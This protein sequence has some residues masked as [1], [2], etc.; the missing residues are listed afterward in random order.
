MR[1]KSRVRCFNYSAYGHFAFECKKPRR[2]R[3]QQ[4]QESNLTR[5]EDD[6]PALLLAKLEPA[7]S[8]V[9]LL[10]DSAVKPQL[11]EKGE[12]KMYES[13]LWYID[14]GSSNHMTGQKSKFKELDERITGRVK[15]GDGSTVDIQGR[16]SIALKC[17]D[18]QE[19]TLNE[20]YF[21]PNLRSNII[22]VGQLTEDG[23]KVVIKGDFMWVYDKEEKLLMKIKKSQNRL[24]RIIIK[25]ENHNCMLSKLEDASKLWH[26]RLGHVNYQ[27]LG[28]MCRDEMV[29]GM[30]RI[31]Q[32]KEL[33][34]G[35]LMLK[36]ARNNIPKKSKFTAQ[37]VLELVHADLYGPITPE[38]AAGNKYFFLLVDDYS[39]LMWVYLLKTKNE[40]FGAFK[41][42]KAMVEDGKERR[43][44][45]LRTDR[46]GEFVSNEFS[47]YCEEA[48]IIRHYTNLYTPQQN[49]VVERRNRTVM[50]MARSLLKGKEMPSYFWGEA[51][52]HAV[53][54]L[55][56]L[57]TRA[58]M[59]TT[60]YETWTSYKPDVGHLPVFG[61][62]GHMK[63]PAQNTQ[64]LDNR[65]MDIV[66]LGRESG[67]KIYRLY[68]PDEN[69]IYVS[70]DVVF[71]ESKSWAWEE[72]KNE[73]AVELTFPVDE[74][75]QEQATETGEQTLVNH[76]SEPEA[77]TSS[78]QSTLP[79]LDPENYD[80]SIEPRRTRLL[81]DVYNDF[82]E[83][84]MDEELYL[85]ETEERAN[86]EEASK[87]KSWKRA[88]EAEI[89]SIEKNNTWRL[90]ELP[91][92][93]KV[94]GLKWIFKLKKDAA[95]NIIKH[96]AR[97]VA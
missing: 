19:R 50:G 82:E 77:G 15:F 96:K 22:S 59:G 45:V 7:E 25:T 95:G 28:L 58:L 94:I 20:V 90:T 37:K 3:E 73:E 75:L 39:R 76:R 62:L 89:D 88:M 12:A 18:G 40:A 21:I 35:C 11:T 70:K 61:Y 10:D 92:E 72:N 66:N 71:E 81:Q 60:P 42:F 79:R 49:G 48:G 51:V 13:N 38:T 63:I 69:R 33:C 55:N 91:A 53:Y 86:F 5:V 65:S 1:D 26:V 83:I 57:P 47:Q 27:A 32:P 9:L 31:I 6:E 16:G 44:K 67:T 78:P 14:N 87:K 36:Q 41:K 46:G 52:R 23:S 93:Q 80:D 85:M 97:L 43:I 8:K 24:Y 4:K 54:V 17:K 30:P 68:S 2:N 34:T 74:L 56:R 29:R 64:K 84:K